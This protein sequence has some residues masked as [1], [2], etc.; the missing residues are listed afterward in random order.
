MDFG[1]RARGVAIVAAGLSL[2]IIPSCGSS[3]DVAPLDAEFVVELQ[4]GQAW[5]ASGPAVE[6]DL[7]CAVGQRRWLGAEDLD[8]DP[9]AIFEVRAMQQEAIAT[10]ELP[11]LVNVD[12]WVCFDGRGSFVSRDPANV[13]TWTIVS[14]K[15]SLAGLSGGGTVSFVPT[16]EDIPDALYLSAA[17]ALGD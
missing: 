1:P 2:L 13:G 4:G 5:S 3:A 15:G 11:A 17:L 16:L 8:G 6:A 12:E 10:R 14:G 7:M 9:L